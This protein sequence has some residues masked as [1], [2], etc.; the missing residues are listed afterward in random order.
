MLTTE[1]KSHSKPCTLLHALVIK[2]PSS[3]KSNYKE[4]II[5]IHESLMYNATRLK[6]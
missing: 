5:P 2:S 1:I 6:L 3:G 4:Y